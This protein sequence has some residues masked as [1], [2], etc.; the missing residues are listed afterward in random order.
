M[1]WVV[2]AA[3]AFRRAAHGAHLAGG[4]AAGVEKIRAVAL[5][6]ADVRAGW[7]L[8]PLEYRAAL[9]IDVAQL[10]LVAFPRAVPQLAVDEAH[11]GHEAVRFDRA[12]NRARARVDL[13][14]LAVAI[15]ADPQGALGPR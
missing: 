1:C 10:A 5:E 8:E 6:P 7:H 9:G 2:S 13:Q 15:L 12:Q 11:A 4:P 14:D 3:R